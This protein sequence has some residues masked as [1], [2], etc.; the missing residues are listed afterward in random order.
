MIITNIYYKKIISYLLAESKKESSEWR[1]YYYG[2]S[3]YDWNYQE[4][5]DAIEDRLNDYGLEASEHNVLIV[6]KCVYVITVHD[7][8]GNIDIAI[9]DAV[10]DMAEEQSTVQ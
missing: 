8:A 10:D 9:A 2:E 4:F 1:N 6:A 5:I 3:D 7:F